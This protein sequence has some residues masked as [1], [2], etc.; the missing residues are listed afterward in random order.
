MT[1]HALSVCLILVRLMI[2]IIDKPPGMWKNVRNIVHVLIPQS[3][4]L[5]DFLNKYIVRTH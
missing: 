4:K 1:F 3:I 2:L 5:V